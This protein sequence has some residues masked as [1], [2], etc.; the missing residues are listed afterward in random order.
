MIRKLYIDRPLKSSVV[1]SILIGV[2]LS[3]IFL[4]SCGSK[5]VDPRT[6]VPADALVYL[7]TSDL[8]KVIE[9]ITS[10]PKF[11][12]LAKTR[13]DTSALNGIKLSVAL[14]GF[15]TF[16]EP[17]SGESAVLNFRPRFVAVAETNAWSYQTLSFAENK[18]GEFVNEIY[19]GEV[20]L[21]IINKHNGRYFTWTALDGRQAF[22]LVR[23]SLILFGND[24]SAIENCVNVMNGGAPNI[25]ANPRITAL[26]PNSLASGYVSKDGVA[27][28]ANI[29]GVSLAIGAGEEAE[30][31]SFIARVLPEIARNSITEVTWTS[32]RLDP[33]RI[34]DTFTI[35]IDP[36][37]AAVLSETVTPGNGQAENMDRFIPTE[38]VSTT[39]Y[40]LND[41]RIAWRSLLLTART[42]TDNVSGGLLTAFS[43]ALFAPYGIDDAETF[44]SAVG[45][46]LQTVRFDAEGDEVAVVA[47]IKDGEALRRAIAKELI[48]SKPPD[49]FENADIWRSADGEMAAAIVGDEIVVGEAK[50]VERCLTARDPGQK[51]TDPVIANSSAPVVTYGRETDPAARLIATLSERK[52]ENEPLTQTYTVES[53]FNQ[54]G[55]ERRTVS[56]FGLIGTIIERLDPQN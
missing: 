2:H 46:T 52:N 9:A 5:P 28:I 20:E 49:K 43:P 31:K 22:A 42:K 12:Q 50:S 55:I 53:R 18:L 44:L 48:L 32:A 25:A 34:E 13:P 47:R 45:N 10:N 8:G 37:T 51:P 54:N 33:G 38:F 15:Q 16:E 4:T 3:I 35:G 23:G 30:A 27:Q 36:E 24:E 14:T 21:V 19:G 41:A 1:M 56:D 26:N 40:N 39:R 29:A 6:V 11:E 17:V 7:E